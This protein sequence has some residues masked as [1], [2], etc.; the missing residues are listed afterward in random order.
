MPEAPDVLWPQGVARPA[1]R[2]LAAAGVRTLKDLA[3]WREADLAALHGMGPKAMAA[4]KQ[5]LAD[6]GLALRA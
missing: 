6:R 1:Q 4:L 2:A 5:A 3:R